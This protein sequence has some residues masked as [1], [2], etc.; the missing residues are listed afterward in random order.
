MFLSVLSADERRDRAAADEVAFFVDDEHAV[1]VAVERHAEVA[2]VLRTAACRSTMFSGSIGLAGMVGKGAVEFEIERYHLA[3]QMFEDV[4]YGFAGHAVACVDR[5]LERFDLDGR[6]T[7]GS[8][9][10][11]RRARRVA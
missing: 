5:D 10:R 8:A 1:G 4:R 2:S 6:R 3:R 11:M 7:K 9:R